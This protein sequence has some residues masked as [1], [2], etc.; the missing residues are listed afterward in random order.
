ME[1]ELKNKLLLTGGSGDGTE[2]SKEKQQGQQ[3]SAAAD[4]QTSSAT[5]ATAKAGAD[6]ELELN[7]I[8]STRNPKDAVA[9]V[10]SGLK[11]IGKGGRLTSYNFNLMLFLDLIASK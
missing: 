8:F 11:S 6:P 1:D 4:G 9:G 2:G 10:S 3:T 5:A 7:S